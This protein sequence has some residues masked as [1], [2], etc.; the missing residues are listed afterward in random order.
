MAVEELR[1]LIW[2]YTPDTPA[3]FEMARGEAEILALTETCKH[4]Q[5]ADGQAILELGCG[6]GSLSLWMAKTYPNARIT[7]VSNSASQPYFKS[8]LSTSDH[9]RRQ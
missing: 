1:R 5:L 9:W 8:G 2:A 6:W 7:G 3:T 4:A